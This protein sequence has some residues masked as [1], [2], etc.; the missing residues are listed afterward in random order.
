MYQ[1]RTLIWLKWTIFRNSLRSRKAK[2]S[3]VASIATSLGALVLALILALALGV[4]SYFLA[5]PRFASQFQTGQSPQFYMFALLSGIYLMWA[6]V[7]LTISGANPFDPGKLMIYPIDLRR[8]IAMDILSELTSIGSIFAVPIMIGIAVG[9]GLATGDLLPTLVLALFA[10]A[11]G[12]SLAKCLSIS[13]AALVKRGRTRGETVVAIMGAVIGLLFAAGGQFLPR[14]MQYSE[15]FEILKWTPPGAIANVFL[16]GTDQRVLSFIATVA[17]VL[18]CTILLTIA[19]FYIARRTALGAGGISRGRRASSLVDQ[20][21]PWKLPAVSHAFSAVIEKETKYLLRNAQFRTLALMPLILIVIRLA[22]PSFGATGDPAKPL[23]SRLQEFAAHSEGLMS[24]AAVLYVFLILSSIF[25]NQ[26][27]FEGAGMRALI[28]APV[29]RRKIL[30]G[31]N[32]VGTGAA[33][34]F[35]I[36]FLIIYQIIFQDATLMHI[37]FAALSFVVFAVGFSLTGN[38][39]SMTFPRRVEFGRN[40]NLAGVSGFL[41]IPLAISL[42]LAPLAAA[43]AGYLAGS[44]LVKY[45]TLSAVALAASGL[46]FFLIGSQAASLS[47]RESEILEA[48]TSKA[49]G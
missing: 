23:P 43:V 45:V 26:F 22:N 36:I 1:L 39:L 28:L 41:L 15:S 46:Y 17:F 14:L 33:L 48:V 12:I 49:E 25:L 34:F 40:M 10:I 38:W 32:F 24:S 2:I 11:F 18:V 13:V 9:A 42:V 4:T 8:L 44:L 5:S 31:K 37:S 29:D 6:T 35:S 3:Q 47:R 7:P 30:A 27:A 19:V 21:Q 20:Y 16:K